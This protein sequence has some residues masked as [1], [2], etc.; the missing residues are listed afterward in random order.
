MPL[1]LLCGT[2]PITFRLAYPLL[3]NYDLVEYIACSGFRCLEQLYI[4]PCLWVLLGNHSFYSVIDSMHFQA[5]EWH[6]D[7]VGFTILKCVFSCT[8]I[9]RR[10]NTLQVEGKRSEKVYRKKI[11]HYLFLRLYTL[12]F[13]FDLQCKVNYL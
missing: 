3:L 13:I 2:I 10:L 12:V 7:F 4:S 5:K 6:H 8:N 9:Q 1:F 11:L